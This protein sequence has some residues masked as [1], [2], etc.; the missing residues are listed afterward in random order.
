VESSGRLHLPSIM[1]T[2]GIPDGEAVS[3]AGAGDDPE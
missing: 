2:D 1:V 3:I